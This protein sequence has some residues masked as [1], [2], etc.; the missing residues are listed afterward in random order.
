MT[1][2]MF[3]TMVAVFALLI[4][5]LLAACGDDDRGLSRLD[6][7]EVVRSELAAAQE[8]QSA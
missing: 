4:V 3:R 7:E 1:G 2:K 8:R 5:V 6:V